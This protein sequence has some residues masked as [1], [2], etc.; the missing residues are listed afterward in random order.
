LTGERYIVDLFPTF[1]WE[2]YTKIEYLT[3]YLGIPAFASYIRTL[4]VKEFPKKDIYVINFVGVLFS[5]TVLFTPAKFYTHTTPLFQIF[6]ILAAGYGFYVLILAI[7]NNRQGAF[8]F[9]A[10]FVILFL[11]LVNDILYSNL[12]LQTGYMI[13]FGLFVFT[14]SQTFLLSFRFSKAYSTVEEQRGILE[15][16][17]E[18]LIKEIAARKRTET[19]KI[20]LTAKLQQIQKMKAI[21]TLAGGI[22]HQFNNAISVIVGNIELLCFE[23]PEFEKNNT[24]LDPI[25][26]S[27][28]RMTQ[29]T[30]QLLAYA[31]GG[32]FQVEEISI[33]D[34]ISSTLPLIQYNIKSTVGVKTDIPHDLLRIKAD[35]IQMQMVMSAIISNASEAID[36]TGC[37]QII[38]RNI[39]ITPENS[40]DFGG[41]KPGPYICLKIE[42]NGKGMDEETRK[43]VFEPF[44]TTKFTGRGLGMAAAYGIIKNHDGW[45]SISSNLGKGTTVFFYLPTI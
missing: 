22:A 45:I 37:I 6:T 39:E 26:H 41:L 44:F 24:I 29:L 27:A 28:N 10:G 2:V 14:F 21:A 18:S 12:L 9:L 25:R 32:K 31:R 40:K 7:I 23:K 33:G 35:L 3:F 20:E 34:F 19:E 43:R 13:Q 5:V 8:V 42:D 15:A 30:D 36:S 1:D 17:N 4:F 16:T 38:G 11:T